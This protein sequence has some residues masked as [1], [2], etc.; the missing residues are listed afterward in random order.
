MINGAP[1]LKKKFYCRPAVAIFFCTT[2]TLSKPFCIK[3]TT[4]N[5]LTCLICLEIQQS[6]WWT[7][8]TK[9]SDGFT[10]IAAIIGSL[11]STLALNEHLWTHHSAQN[12]TLGKGKLTYI[13]NKY[14]NKLWRILSIF[15]LQFLHNIHLEMVRCL[16]CYQDCHT[17]S[18]QAEV[19]SFIAC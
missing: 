11:Q 15:K 8:K 16:N 5:Y 3:H 6:N 14:G 18:K 10:I 12:S 2:Q 1:W 17:P 4:V 7:I 9:N 13:N 19:S